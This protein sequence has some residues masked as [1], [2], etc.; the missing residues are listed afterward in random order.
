MIIKTQT[1][2]AVNAQCYKKEIDLRNWCP[3]RVV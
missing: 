2:N 1:A 3:E